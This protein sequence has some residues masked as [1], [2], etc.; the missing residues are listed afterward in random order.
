[1]YST[2]LLKGAIP[3]PFAIMING[4]VGMANVDWELLIRRVLGRVFK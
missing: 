3:L 1:M 2:M 4:L